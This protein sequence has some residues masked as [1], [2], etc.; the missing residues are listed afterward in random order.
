MKNLLYAKEMQKKITL[1][2]LSIFSLL[3]PLAVYGQTLESLSLKTLVDQF[4]KVVGG[5]LIPLAVAFLFF[6]F[7]LNIAKYIQAMNTG[8]SDITEMAKKRL[9]YPILILF[10]I[11]TIWGFVYLLRVLFTA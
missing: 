3:L 1:I 5:L 2:T 8:N 4:I 10:T 11:F 7:V 6:I 9:L